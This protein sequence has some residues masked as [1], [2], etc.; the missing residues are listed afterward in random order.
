MKLRVILLGTTAVLGC[1][2]ATL[3][4]PLAAAA[5]EVTAGGYPDLQITGFVR[6]RVHGGDINEARLGGGEDGANFSDELDFSNDTEVHVVARAA[7]EATG[8]EYGGSIEF[9]TD[10]SRTDNTD[11][12]FVFLRG[13]WGEV[14]L[15]DE[16][17]PADRDGLAVSAAEVAA[18]GDDGLD[19]DQFEILFANVRTLGPVHQRR[20]QGALPKPVLPG[21]GQSPARR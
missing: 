15:G 13:G 3:A 6:F 21:R 16:D 14:R 5:A 9:E 19:Q 12:T 20:D 7:S 2:G 10:T 1:G 18:A 11:E 17:G 4:C 8:L